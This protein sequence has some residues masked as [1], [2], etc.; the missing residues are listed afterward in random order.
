MKVDTEDRGVE[1][2]DAVPPIGV[3]RI[4]FK[5]KLARNAMEC[6]RKNVKRKLK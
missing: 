5:A 3:R 4:P 1:E 2:D 6:N